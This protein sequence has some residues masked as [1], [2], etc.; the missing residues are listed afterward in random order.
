MTAPTYRNAALFN[1]TF[2]STLTGNFDVGVGPNTTIVALAFNAGGASLVTIDSLKIGGV[3]MTAE[4]ASAAIG[5]G[6]VG[7]RRS[8]RLANQSMTGLQAFEMTLVD[9]NAKPI[10]IFYACSGTTTV[11]AYSAVAPST[12]FT[13][14][15]A[16]AS[17][18][19]SLVVGLLGLEHGGTVAADSPTVERLEVAEGFLV[20]TGYAMDEPGAAGT[21]TV[22]TTVTGGATPGWF[23]SVWS[24]QGTGDTTAPVLTLP[25]GAQTGSSTANIGATTDEGNGGIYVVATTEITTPTAAQVRAGQRASG[26]AANAAANAAVGSTGA[27]IVGVTGLAASTAYYGHSMHEDAAGNRSNVV[28][29]AQFTTASGTDTTPPTMNGAA[30]VTAKGFTLSWPA[31]SDNVAVTGYEVSTNGGTNWTDNGNSTTR[32]ISGLADGTYAVRVRAY[33]AAGNRAATPLQLSVTI[34]TSGTN[35]V[36]IVV[37]TT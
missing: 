19:N 24:I 28:T 29:S 27:K 7:Q 34:N 14:T 5:G 26:A 23:G 36:V 8:F 35:P 16:V 2:A 20:S 1:S 33:D 32:V 11:D 17:D 21:V 4:A 22:S 9:A 13:A 18:T 37:S 12:G 10:V 15:G 3:F 25:T 31:G 30:S 6:F